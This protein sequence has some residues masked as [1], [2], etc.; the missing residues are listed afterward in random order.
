MTEETV[1]ESK[2]KSTSRKFFLLVIVLISVIA[3]AGFFATKAG[4][5]KALVKQ[6][7]DNIAEEMKQ[8]AAKSGQD[9]SL[10]YKD[11]I[12]EGGFSNRHAVIQSP[13]LIRKDADGA[14]NAY[15]TA[16]IALY[17]TSADLQSFRIEADKPITLHEQE[18]EDATAVLTI[19]QKS[20]IVATIAPKSIDGVDYQTVMVNLP[21]AFLIDGPADKASDAWNKITL[22]FAPG[23]FL[24]SELAK[25]NSDEMGLGKSSAGL[26]SIV[27]TPDAAP[28]DAITINAI[29]FD[30]SNA[31]NDKKLNDISLIAKIDTIASNADIMPYGAVNFAMDASFLGK[32]PKTPQAFSEAEQQESVFKLKSFTFSSE[33]AAIEANADFT[34]GVKDVLPVGTA[35]VTVKSLDYIVSELKLKQLLDPLSEN[36]LQALVQQISG[37]PLA[38]TKDLSIDIKRVR[39]G[40]FFI[41][42]S[43]FEDIVAK[44]FEI[45][46]KSNSKAV[47][48]NNKPVAEP[49]TKPSD[50]AVESEG[51]DDEYEIPQKAA[52]AE[53]A[54]PVAHE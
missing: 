17:P 49:T 10:T 52:P 3:G 30:Y 6:A 54:S 24:S 37:K 14:I 32:L 23:G 44:I 31:L 41:G 12:I 20:A 34:A 29:T 43:T 45:S 21:E 36:L 46:L 42:K 51:N 19:T 11:I 9:V 25:N 28:K 48:P 27:I 38:E 5:D 13:A 2:P 16:A 22:T 8:R 35:N 40:A 4:L 26:K 39:D 53:P 50:K 1:I 33:Q 18:V 47:A 15:R 7:I